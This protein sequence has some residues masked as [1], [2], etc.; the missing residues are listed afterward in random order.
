MN[1]LNVRKF[2]DPRS[3]FLRFLSSSEKGLK[4]DSNP[5]LFDVFV[6]RVKLI[7][8]KSFEFIDRR[9]LKSFTS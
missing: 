7:C 6:S 3:L 4:R 1:I 2:Y 9:I 8:Y 5:D